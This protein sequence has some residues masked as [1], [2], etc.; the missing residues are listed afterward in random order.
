MISVAETTAEG[1]VVGSSRRA[2][3]RF[4]L[5]CRAHLESR[6]AGGAFVFRAWRAEGPAAGGS[7]HAPRLAQHVAGP[8]ASPRAGPFAF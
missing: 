3:A 2:P 8:S 7:T 5:G 4:S 6:E 1:R